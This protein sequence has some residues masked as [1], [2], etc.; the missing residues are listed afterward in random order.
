MIKLTYSPFQCTGRYMYWNKDL[1]EAAGLDP[2]TPPASYEEWTE[3]AS[4]ITDADKN[5]YGSGVSYT[6]VSSNLQVMQRFGG[7]VSEPYG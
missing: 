3:M 7:Q 6:D 1:F 2:D 5:V 4:K